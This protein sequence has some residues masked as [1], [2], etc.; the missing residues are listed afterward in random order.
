MSSSWSSSYTREEPENLSERQACPARGVVNA[1]KGRPWRAK[2]GSES[3][4][5][6]KE[7]ERE[8]RLGATRLDDEGTA[9]T[10]LVLRRN[11]P[12]ESRKRSKSVGATVDASYQNACSQGY[13]GLVDWPSDGGTLED[14]NR[15]L[16]RLEGR[17]TAQIVIL[18]LIRGGSSAARQDRD[19]CC[20]QGGEITGQVQVQG[21]RGHPAVLSEKDWRA[22]LRVEEERFVGF[23][24]L[25][26]TDKWVLTWE[27]GLYEDWPVHMPTNGKG[28]K[29]GG[30]DTAPPR[31][32][33]KK[34][35]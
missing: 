31:S 33:P 30:R 16:G 14:A 23:R 26:T 12:T 22:I 19:L 15:E 28:R 35:I 13:L 9:T 11:M 6:S 1:D 27:P 21:Y 4:D 32:S 29:Q 18:G 5:S 24:T 7:G 20:T 25:S 2:K 10:A 8:R 17:E 3:S 34:S